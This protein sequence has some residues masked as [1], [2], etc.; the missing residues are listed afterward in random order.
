MVWLVGITGV[1]WL[2]ACATIIGAVRSRGWLAKGRGLLAASA[3]LCLGLLL[4]GLLMVVR[5]FQAFSGETLVARVATMQLSPERFELRYTPLEQT[6]ASHETLRLNLR[7]DQWAISGG[8]VKWQPWLTA[9]GLP[10]Y[11]RPARLSGQF[12]RIEQQRAQPPTV[13]PITPALDWFWE[14]LYRMDPY[15]PFVEAVYGSSAYVYVEPDIVQ[16]IYVTPS[17]YIIK[18]VPGKP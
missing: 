16:E 7:G 8:I 4:G 5:A 18:R 10:S 12:S 13:Y 14:G 11:H 17:G 3:W 6:A 15:L 2:V 9:L 1:V